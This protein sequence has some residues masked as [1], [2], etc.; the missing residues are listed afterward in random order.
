MPRALPHDLSP[1]RFDAALRSFEG[2]VGKPWVLSGEEDL[3]PYA[4]AY[5]L[6]SPGDHAPSAVVA[7]A[8]A[9]EVQ[10]IMRL[11]NQHRTPLWPISRGKN[12]G[13]GGAAPRMAG[14]V[15]LDLGRM[16]RILEVDVARGYCLL[17]PGVSFYDLYDHLIANRIPLWASTP[18]N[19]LGSVVGNALEHGLGY[20]TTGDRAANV[21]GLE[22]VLPTGELVRTGMGAMTGNP[23]WNL[24]KYSYGASFDQ[25]FMQSGLGVVTKMGCWLM[26]EPDAALELKMEVPNEEDIGWVIEALAPLR[27]SGVVQSPINIGNF[28]RVIMASSQR[29][30]WHRGQGAIPDAMF[31]EIMKKY[32]LGW[33][34]VG[35]MLY[36]DPDVVRAQAAQVK[37]AFAQHTPQ[38]FQETWWRRGEPRP[39]G[40]THGVP[41]S[42]PLRIANWAG[43]N[44]GHLGF[45]PILP[46]ER[47]VILEQLKRARALFRDFGFDFYG[48]FTLG[49]RHVNQVNMLAYAKDD[50]DMVRRA[51][52]LFEA[53]MRDAKGRNFGEYRSHLSY[54]DAVA[55]TYDFNGHA[56]QRLNETV[57]DALDPNGVLAPG[58]QGV[59]P[60]RYRGK[61][62]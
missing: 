29:D 26:P 30:Q 61:R 42:F 40:P 43:P 9:E 32:G 24:Y 38:P 27:M 55:E 36:G 11:A 16:R 56:L 51:R 34:G 23:C 62:T 47:G 48:G 31:P 53:L 14:T 15:I 22:V 20:T 6:A 12:Y 4:D 37:R 46:P 7:P 49:E 60:K 33:W 50:P 3:V 54:M 17:E 13:Y 25:M 57:K 8:S 10:A 44:G 19:A 21:C 45:S 59:W 2:V 41:I 1:G 39:P 58:K 52:G 18:G 35:L 5:G 28:M